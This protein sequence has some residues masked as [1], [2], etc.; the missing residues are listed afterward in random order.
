MGAG[1]LPPRIVPTASTI[2]AATSTRRA[3]YCIQRLARGILDHPGG[4]GLVCEMSD[5]DRT[6][7]SW[8]SEGDE[9]IAQL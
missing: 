8:S 6:R 4:R 3:P 1:G 2:P 7:R 5:P 9:Q